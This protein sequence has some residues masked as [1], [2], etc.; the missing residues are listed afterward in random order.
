MF[1]ILIVDDD[2]TIRRLLERTLKKQ[3]YDLYVAEDGVEGFELACRERPSLIVCDWMMPRMDGIEVCRRIRAEPELSTTFMILL[4]SLGSVED[5]VRGLDAGADD[6]LSKPI[7]MN[8]LKARVRAGLRLHQLSRDLQ[9]QKALLEAELAEAADYVQSLLPGDLS[10]AGNLSIDELG[11]SAKL[12]LPIVP[13]LDSSLPPGHGREQ[14]GSTIWPIAVTSQ[15]VPSRKLGGDC[16]D[17]FWL[18]S[19]RL[20]LYLVDAAGHGLKAALPSL[21]VLNL[22]RSQALPGLN[23]AQ[24]SAVLAAL[25]Q[26]FQM[27]DRNDKYFTMWYGLYNCRDRQLTYASAGHPPGLLIHPN[28]QVDRLRTPGLPIGM[29]A[30]ADYA[31]ATCD[32]VS[33]SVLYVFSDGIYEIDQPDGTIWGL[34]A[35]VN[36][37]VDCEAHDCEAAA[38]VVDRVRQHHHCD[39]FED[40]LSLLRVQLGQI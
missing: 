3:G 31:D 36:L 20:A 2:P 26:T 39:R 4:T 6:F 21:S 15:F 9:V 24:P 23:Y 19:D 1:K 30:E 33:G 14:P 28:H 17:F 13:G 11:D 18:D 34:E 16:F 38:T 37:L 8:E 40:D 7:E 10:E 25:N 5:R 29:F 35:L 32:V 27:S 22:L 12:L